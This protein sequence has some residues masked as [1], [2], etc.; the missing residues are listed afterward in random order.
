MK[1]SKWTHGHNCTYSLLRFH[2]HKLQDPEKANQFLITTFLLRN[3]FK[4]NWGRP[5]VWS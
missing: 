3:I 4:L 5:V 1:D 2:P